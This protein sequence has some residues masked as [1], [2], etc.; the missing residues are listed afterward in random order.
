VIYDDAADLYDL[1]YAAY[2]DDVPHYLRLADDLGGP[3]LELGAGTGRLTEALARA[4]HEV[5]AVDVAPAMLARARARVTAPNVRFVEADM[6]ALDLGQQFALVI[7]PFNTL[8]HA[9][10]L[11]DQDSTLAGVHRHLA[12]GGTFAFDV[13][14]PHLGALG[15]MRREETWGELAE[16]TELFLI[17]HHDAEAQLVE[18]RYYFDEVLT[19]GLVRR[20]T[21]RLLQRYYHR[22]ELERALAQA[23]F[24]QVRLFGGF[25]KSRL[26]ASSLAIVGSASR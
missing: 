3:I 4:G 9:Y 20:R 16:G 23:G 19:D 10:T 22:Y 7:A 1:Q 18:S 5:V 13:Y 2:R 24:K 8:M 12:Q 14:Q 26:L 11:S 25:D 17:Q 15:V 6:R 21:A